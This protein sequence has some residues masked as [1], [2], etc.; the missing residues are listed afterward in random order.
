MRVKVEC[1]CL[2]HNN[3][4]YVTGR[5]LDLP[6]DVALEL[7]ERGDVSAVGKVIEPAPLVEEKA[8]NPIEESVEETIDEEPVEEKTNEPVEEMALP[9]SR[10]EIREL[11][12]KLM[13][14]G[15][16]EKF[17]LN[18]KTDE[19]VKRIKGVI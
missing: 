5:E 3:L 16:L 12:K 10:Q 1:S 7:I 19:I 13:E 4:H 11:A 6:T 15:K 9:E 2:L 8:D 17:S 14:E 18:L